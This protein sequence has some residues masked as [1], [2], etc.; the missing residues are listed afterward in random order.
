[1]EKKFFGMC[2]AK[3]YKELMEKLLKNLLEIG[4]N[5]SIKVHFLHC[6]LDKFTDNSGNASDEQ[7]NDSI[8]ISK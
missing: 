1:M 4:P 2:R 7:E 5:M 6:H 3:N 8:K